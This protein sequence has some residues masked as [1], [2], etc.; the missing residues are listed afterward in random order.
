LKKFKERKSTCR[1]PA[2]RGEND[3]KVD[4]REIGL[5]DVDGNYLSRDRVRDKAV[6]NTVMKSLGTA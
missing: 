5:E 4:L 6:L 3:I 1:R 2:V